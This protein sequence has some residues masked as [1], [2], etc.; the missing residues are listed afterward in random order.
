MLFL[1]K[2]EINENSE[3]C[4]FGYRTMDSFTKVLRME[5]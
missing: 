2:L 1:L 3:M 4:G 5:V